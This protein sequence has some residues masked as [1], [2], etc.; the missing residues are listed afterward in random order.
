[1]LLDPGVCM[2]VPFNRVTIKP[3]DLGNVRLDTI[4]F[5]GVSQ[6]LAHVHVTHTEHGVSC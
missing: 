6:Q 2:R 4:D 1:M 3:A 5:G